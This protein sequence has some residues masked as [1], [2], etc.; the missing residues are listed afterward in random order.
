MNINC[1]PPLQF[2]YFSTDTHIPWISHNTLRD[3]LFKNGVAIRKKVY[4]FAMIQKHSPSKFAT[5]LK[6]KIYK[7]NKNSQL[8]LC[9]STNTDI[10]KLNLRFNHIFLV[11]IN[12]DFYCKLLMRILFMNLS[13]QLVTYNNIL[14]LL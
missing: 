6:F 8:F 11:I 9:V 10:N 1:Q 2:V 4:S 12:R 5:K 14:S 3:R 7:P 13:T